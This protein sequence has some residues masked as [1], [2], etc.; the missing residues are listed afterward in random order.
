MRILAWPAYDNQ[1]GNPY[2]RLLYAP[3]AQLGVTVDEFSPRRAL[4]S[5][6][7]GGHDCWH[8][9]WP[10]DLLSITPR[11]AAA[12][13]VAALLALMTGARARGIRMV[14]T[15]HDLGP[16]ESPHPRLERFFWRHFI[17]RV[18][19]VISLSER[20]LRA[21]RERFPRLRGRPGFAIPHGHY[22]EAYPP[23]PPKENA[24]RELDLP[25]G[26]P[27]ALFVG[28]IRPY[29]NVE[30]L[31]EVFR[32]MDAPEEARLVVAG[33]PTGD[34]LRRRI[35]AAAAG[36]ERV[37]LALRFIP[38]ARLPTYLAAADLVTLPYRDILHSG[39]ALLAL[40][41]DRPVLVPGRGAMSELQEQIGSRW[42]RT[43]GPSSN[44]SSGDAL[45]PGA[46]REA[47]RWARREDRPARAPLGGFGWKHIAAQTV[48]AYRA[49]AQTN[50]P[51]QGK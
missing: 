48:E 23:A 12:W 11:R 19:G 28:R 16:H 27:V 1:T 14:W 51:A 3:M 17:P 2:N 38:E 7:W 37:H 47:L 8:L 6:L 15:A 22:R 32:E 50:K 34:T 29:K 20:G 4:R 43:C 21:A 39:S 36:A 26:A 30:R 31:I 46:L 45:T 40:S 24:R 33:N 13:R 9:H 25:L 42:V 5:A 10:D 18:D 44:G 41:F 49:V 35:E